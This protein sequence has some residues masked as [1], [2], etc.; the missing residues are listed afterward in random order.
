MTDL[1]NLCPAGEEVWVTY[2]SRDSLLFFM[3]VPAG[4][5]ST[6]AAKNGAFTLYSVISG[7]GGLKA[8]KLG[9]GGNPK[10]LE[11]KY[12]IDEAV[13]SVAKAS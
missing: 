4:M 8:K 3:T 2:Y 1:R 13:K 6:L 10:E 5:S 12:K 11:D 9:S 7:R